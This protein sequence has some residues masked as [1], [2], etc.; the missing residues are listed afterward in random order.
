M[1]HDM[2]PNWMMLM[3]MYHQRN[4]NL[5]RYN[6]HLILNH[7]MDCPMDG[8]EFEIVS[9]IIFLDYVGYMFHCTGCNE[10]RNVR[11]GADHFVSHLYHVQCEILYLT[12]S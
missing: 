2:T 6:K 5:K 4:K 9:K 12:L 7:K 3:L 11:F 1:L 10:D 8:F